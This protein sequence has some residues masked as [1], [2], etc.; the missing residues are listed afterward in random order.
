MSEKSIERRQKQGILV[1]YTDLPI[2]PLYISQL[3]EAGAIVKAK[4]K[5]V[6]TVTVY[7]PDSSA[8]P[9]LEELNFVDTLYCVWKGLLP[10][11]NSFRIK[12]EPEQDITKIFSKSG[13]DI[14]T[15][16]Q[17]Y[18]QINMLHGDLLHDNGFTG[19][20]M[21]IAVIDIGYQNSDQIS[22]FDPE[23]IKE[24]KDFTHKESDLFRIAQGHGTAV[25]SCM[26]SNEPGVMVGTA[27]DAD[28]YLFKSEVENEEFPVEEDY[29]VAAMEYADS[30]GVDVVNTSLG[31]TT[32]DEAD[33]NHTHE[34]LDGKTIP[35]SRAGAL[36][37]KKGMLIFIAAGNEGNK[38][39]KKIAVPGDAENIITVA[40]VN[41]SQTIAAF[42]SR[43]PSADNRVKPDLSSMGEGAAIINGAKNLTKGNGTSYA[44]PILAGISACLWQSLPDKTSEE[45]RTLLLSSGDRFS[46]PDSIYGYGIPDVYK[47]YSETTGIVNI[48]TDNQSVF[49]DSRENKLYIKTNTNQNISARIYNSLGQIEGEY[50]QVT[51]PIDLNALLKGMYIIRIF[52]NNKLTIQKFIK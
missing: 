27:P 34:Q 38:N 15:Y 30:I 13:T 6:E 20:G 3:E 10:D 33:M 46:E 36:A 43:G 37:G 52:Q 11:N 41:S 50:R 18:A 14:N 17:G 2:D 24:I 4:S 9:T 21:S 16:G 44:S 48:K 39:W 29:W 31:Y 5:W 40:A 51:S 19:K 47:V 49:F 35:A 12:K 23:R 42:S 28:Y 22:A 32:F 45:I 8:I 26:L 1:D 25:L 7:L